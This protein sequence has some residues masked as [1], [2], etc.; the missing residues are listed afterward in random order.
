MTAPA[1]PPVEAVA[2]RVRELLERDG[3]TQR[4]LAD[5]IDL[6]ETKLSKSLAGRRRFSAAELVALASATGV[7]VN[8]LVHGRDDARTHTALPS[9]GATSPTTRDG[10]RTRTRILE[11]A[12]NAIADHGY[13]AVRTADVARACGLGPA[14][15][16]RHFPRRAEMLDEALRHSVKLA[17][18][19]QVAELD[20][21]ADPHRRLLRLIDLQLPGGELL[22]R[23]WSIWMQVWAEAATDPSRRALAGEAYDRWY[24][25]VLMTLRDGATTGVFVTGRAETLA[26]QLVGLI[27]G[28]GIQVVAGAPGSDPDAMRAVVHDFIDR[29]VLAR[30]AGAEEREDQ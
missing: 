12:W 26:R 27:D 9:G 2:A 6:D 19:R 7:T 8:H 13:H 30:P 18:D 14:A 16:A 24:R 4:R 15:V 23:E 11:A 29:A 25:T 3:W 17:F 1:A 22:R 20:G 5:A 28:L 10:R 21:V